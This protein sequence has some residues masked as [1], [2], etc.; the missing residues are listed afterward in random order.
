MNERFKELVES[1]DDLFQELKAMKPVKV[2]ELPKDTPTS[3]IYVFYEGDTALYVGR[4]NRLC[5]RLQEH[6]RRSA[7]HNTAPFAFRLAREATNQTEATYSAEGSRSDLENDPDFALAFK[8]AKERVRGM[9]VRFVEEKNQ[10]RQALLEIYVAVALDTKY[11][12]FKTS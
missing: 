2:T 6:G 3:G 10:L 1:L 8:K 11:N 7:G 12:V 5:A 4:S 9:T